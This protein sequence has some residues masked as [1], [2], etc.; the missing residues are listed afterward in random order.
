MIK[1]IKKS[2]TVAIPGLNYPPDF[3]VRAC[4]LVLKLGGSFGP[5]GGVVWTS[6]GGRPCEMR[7]FRKAFSLNYIIY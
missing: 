6:W 2:S 4:C 3:K 5:R 1:P 7:R